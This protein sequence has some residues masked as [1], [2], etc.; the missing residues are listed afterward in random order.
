MAR[1]RASAVGMKR[2][3]QRLEALAAARFRDELLGER[4]A[5]ARRDHPAD[6]VPTE[7]IEHDVEIEM[8][9]F[10]R[11]FELGAV[12]APKLFRLRGERLRTRMVWVTAL[13]APVADLTVSRK[14]TVHRALRAEVTAF[15]EHRCVDLGGRLVDEARLVERV[16]HALTFGGRERAWWQWTR[17]RDSWRERSSS[18]L[19]NV[20]Q[21]GLGRHFGR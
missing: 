6:D 15:V 16:E 4:R 5:L 8:R 2:Q 1:H 13:V 9:P 10:R 12:P 19:V 3:L 11:T 14:K 17:P 21:R 20:R 7:V 18:S